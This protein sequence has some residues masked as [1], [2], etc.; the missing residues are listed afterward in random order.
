MAAYIDGRGSIRRGRQ[1]GGPATLHWV[2]LFAALLLIATAPDSASFTAHA[3]ADQG[4]LSRL[5]TTTYQNLLVAA[6]G[7]RGDKQYL[8]ALGAWLRLPGTAT[9]SVEDDVTALAVVLCLVFALVPPAVVQRHFSCGRA[10][11]CRPYTLVTYA[12]AHR[13]LGHLAVNVLQLWSMGGV[14]R[15]ALGRTG[16]ALLCVGGA[17]AGGSVSAAVRGPGYSTVGASGAVYALL[18]HAVA[19]DPAATWLYLGHPVPAT[20]AVAAQLAIEFASS[21]TVDAWCHLGGG[22]F[23]WWWCRG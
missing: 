4:V 22:L 6:W 11:L 1:Q 19:R 13:D 16:F 18:A 3:N 12:L 10:N 2:L 7:T 5:L 9:W 23:G 15:M 21:G 8:G 17:F 20:H 14:V